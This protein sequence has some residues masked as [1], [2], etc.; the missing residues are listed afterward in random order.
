MSGA[1]SHYSDR[2]VALGLWAKPP[3]VDVPGEVRVKA[4]YPFRQKFTTGGMRL[5]RFGRPADRN[6]ADRVNRAGPAHDSSDRGRMDPPNPAGPQSP[7]GGLEDQVFTG[8]A[9]IEGG[10]IDSRN[11][12]TQPV[13]DRCPG[14]AQGEEDRCA[15][16]PR[17]IHPGQ[18]SLVAQAET[19]VFI[20]DDG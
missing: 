15:A 3:L 12:G 18:K 20:G 13:G 4:G 14:D 8:N 19:P 5:A 17:A 1:Y 7:S 11:E 6:Q 10:I 16:N 2:S 9:E